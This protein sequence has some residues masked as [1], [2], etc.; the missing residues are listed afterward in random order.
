MQPRARR[1]LQAARSSCPE[2]HRSLWGLRLRRADYVAP[3]ALRTASIVRATSR[4][5]VRQLTTQ[6]RITR[7]PAQV[8]GPKYA[9]PL[10]LIAAITFSVR[11]S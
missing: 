4:S 5:V 8:D 3:S 1:F 9:S 11:A 6:I 7:F 10:A 2:W